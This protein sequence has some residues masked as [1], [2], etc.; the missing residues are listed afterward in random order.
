MSNPDGKESAKRSTFDSLP[1]VPASD[2]LTEPAA[3]QSTIGRKDE[4]PIEAIRHQDAEPS[5]QARGEECVDLIQNIRLLAPHLLDDLL[6]DGETTPIPPEPSSHNRRLDPA[7]TTD[8]DWSYQP[9]IGRFTLLRELGRGGNGVV[10][11]CEDPEL[12][13]QV[14]LK[15][16]RPEVL[17]TAGLRRRFIREAEA[18]ACLSH[19]NIIPV[20]EAGRVGPIHYIASAYCP[21]LTLRQWLEQIGGKLHPLSAVRLTRVLVDAVHHAHSRGVLHRDIKPSNVIMDFSSDGNAKAA[22]QDAS[23]VRDFS[24]VVKLTDFGLARTSSSEETLSSDIVGTP[25]Y[26]APEQAAGKNSEVTVTADVYAIGVILYQLLTGRPPF[27]MENQLDTLLAVRNRDP[28]RP[29][30]FDAAISLDLEAICLKCLEKK[31]SSRY[32]TAAELSADLQQFL[33]GNPVTAR[34]VSTATRSARWIGRHPFAALGILTATILISLAAVSVFWQ[35]SRAEKSLAEVEK[36]QQRALMHLRSAQNAVDELLTEVSAHLEGVPQMEALRESLL[37]KA[38]QFN[39]RFISDEAVNDSMKLELVRALRRDAE[40]QTHLGNF[41]AAQAAAKKSIQ[42]GSSMLGQADSPNGLEREIASAHERLGNCLLLQRKLNE[43]E[44]HFRAALQLLN[45][46]KNE[47]SEFLKTDLAELQRKLGMNLEQRRQFDQAAKWFRQSVD[48]LSGVKEASRTNSARNQMAKSLGS[49]GISHKQRGQFEEAL[50]CYEQSCQIL[51]SLVS[52]SPKLAHRR[53]LATQYLNLAN[54]CLYTKEYALAEDYYGRCATAAETLHRD[55]PLTPFFHSLVC[56][57]HNGIGI[58]NLR[59]G[60]PKEAIHSLEHAT[61]VGSALIA[62]H[63]QL[64]YLEQAAKAY[65]TLGNTLR[66][67]NSLEK[68]LHALER[69]VTIGTQLVATFPKHHQGRITLGDACQ[70]MA[71]TYFASEEYDLAEDALRKAI[72]TRSVA[73][74]HIPWALT[75]LIDD[76]GMLASAVTLQNRVDEAIE[77]ITKFETLAPSKPNGLLQSATAYC[78][79]AVQLQAIEQSSNRGF[80]CQTAQRAA[81]QRLQEVLEKNMCDAKVLQN[82]IFDA[83]REHPDFQALEAK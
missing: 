3:L 14:A 82:P 18:A 9:Q 13:R 7:C 31:P 35:W 76:Y 75:E 78:G 69:A 32:A 17:M 66:E 60:H 59:L 19:P 71:K 79:L 22:S 1:R 6:G 74:E 25:A 10:F 80:T 81:I 30:R 43:S 54:L 72:E 42:L 27:Q 34:P 24:K 55:F 26:M 4:T 16:P 39:E 37:T 70:R 45:S 46:P 36:Q 44:K 48:T 63:Q 49:L 62:K 57:A 73:A 67:Q 12:K 68:S 5:D 64:T 15:V 52:D 61:E 56:S 58:A 20:Y 2:K 53:L 77:I 29:R 83:I 21:G 11:L 33:L 28:E 50:S 47:S 40:M 41:V 51:E 8:D 23:E 65:S 38:L